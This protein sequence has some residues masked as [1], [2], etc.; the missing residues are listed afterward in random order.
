[1]N[2]MARKHTA[3]PTRDRHPEAAPRQAALRQEWLL[4]AVRYVFAAAMA[5]RRG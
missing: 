3:T 2:E 5:D 4:D 1:M